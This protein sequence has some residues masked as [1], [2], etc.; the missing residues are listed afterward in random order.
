VGGAVVDLAT[1]VIDGKSTVLRRGQ[2]VHVLA[3]DGK[4]LRRMETDG[5]SGCCAVGRDQP[6][7]GGCAD[8]KVIAF[9]AKGDRRWTFV[10]EMDPAV[11]RAAKHTGSSRP[12]GHS[13]VAHGVFIDGKE[14]AFV[15]SACTLEILDEARKLVRRKPVFW[16]GDGFQIIDAGDGSRNLLVG[17]SRTTATAWPSSTAASSNPARAGSTAYRPA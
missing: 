14:Q 7:A 2:G 8:E 12:S 17:A 9:D 10:S 11:F 16:A 3:A 1:G 13:R 6:A 4:E 5:R 15:G